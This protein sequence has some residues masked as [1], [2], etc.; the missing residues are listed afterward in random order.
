MGLTRVVVILVPKNR[1]N[2]GF[3]AV[4]VEV[5]GQRASPRVVELVTEQ[6]DSAAPE[7]DLKQSG[8]D[9]LDGKNVATDSRERLCAR[10]RQP[11]V[12]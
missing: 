12:R 6:K 3:G 1:H 11:F 5:L 2:V 10:F 8:H 9:R 7:A 4:L